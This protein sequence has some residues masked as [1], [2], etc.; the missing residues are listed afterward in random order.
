MDV[1]QVVPVVCFASTCAAALH[2]VGM[3]VVELFCFNSFI[4]P[5]VGGICSYIYIYIFYH[6][7]YYVIFKLLL[8][9]FFKQV[10]ICIY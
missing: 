10:D 1:V 7:N 8:L 4:K 3:S 5:T 9:I 2:Q 6:W